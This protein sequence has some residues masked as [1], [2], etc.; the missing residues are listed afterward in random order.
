[1]ERPV[2]RSPEAHGLSSRLTILLTITIFLVIFSLIVAMT[3]FRVDT[4]RT[5]SG[6]PGGTLAEVTPSVVGVLSAGM[7]RVAFE[8]TDS[9]GTRQNIEGLRTGHI[10]IA[11]VYEGI[12][13]R[14]VLHSQI[15]TFARLYVNPLHVI[16]SVKSGI[17]GFEDI[18][19]HHRIGIPPSRVAS[20]K[21][22]SDVLGHYGIYKSSG[23]NIKETPNFLI[24]A[25]SLK[26]G[27]VDLAFFGGAIPIPAI[28]NYFLPDATLFRFVPIGA[29]KAIALRNHQ[30][31]VFTIPAMGYIGNPPFPR[32]DIETIASVASLVGR[33]SLEEELG[34]GAMY[35]MTKALFDSRSYLVNSHSYLRTMS[36][37]FSSAEPEY[38]LF[39]GSSDY[40]NRNRPIVWDMVTLYVSSVFSLIFL[41]LTVTSF[42]GR[43]RKPHS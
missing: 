15:R 35:K 10:D 21:R 40:Y 6:V 41:L 29:S 37:R 8:I 23:Y 22:A 1:M 25:H 12:K 24:A 5:G 4:L 42:V 19:R 20:H 18:S 2:D 11:I 32:K 36:E 30:Y 27:Q 34:E 28:H 16:A 26:T 31:T 33:A 43:R 38:P 39:E 17:Q 13:P 3:L 14:V 9:L 7:D